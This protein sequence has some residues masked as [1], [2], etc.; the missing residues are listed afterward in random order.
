MKTYKNRIV[1]ATDVSFRDELLVDLRAICGTS[2]S[3]PITID[4]ALTE[5]I[6]STIGDAGIGTTVLAV[7]DRLTRCE[8][9]RA[10]ALPICQEGEWFSGMILNS[11]SCFDLGC[12]SGRSVSGSIPASRRSSHSLKIQAAA[13]SNL[14][15]LVV[16]D[17]RLLSIGSLQ[18]AALDSA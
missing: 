8:L 18:R 7:D 14:S 15:R 3:T 1:H 5:A 9:G 4:A 13:G 12:K 11:R 17:S 6:G 10:I 2:S 16:L